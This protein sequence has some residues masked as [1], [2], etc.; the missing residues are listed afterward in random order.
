MTCPE[1]RY[2]MALAPRQTVHQS[3]S[4]ASI[5]HSCPCQ[6]RVPYFREKTQVQDMGL[7]IRGTAVPIGALFLLHSIGLKMRDW[8]SPED[9]ST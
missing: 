5:Q 8:Y 3:P 6:F 9:R 1:V 7:G 4:V 2:C